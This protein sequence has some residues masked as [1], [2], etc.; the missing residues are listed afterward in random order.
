MLGQA[1][2]VLDWSG[3]EGHV[4][5]FGER[6]QA[7]ATQALTQGELVRITRIEGLKLEVR[8]MPE[9]VTSPGGQP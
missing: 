8:R 7:Q 3:Q 5:A 6:W 4:L 2:E 9:L 1:A